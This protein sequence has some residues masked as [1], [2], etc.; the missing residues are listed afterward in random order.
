MVRAKLDA[1][2]TNL[3]AASVGCVIKSGYLI[4]S[5]ANIAANVDWASAS[6]P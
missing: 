4:F 5:W 3:G 2:K 1:F 6:K